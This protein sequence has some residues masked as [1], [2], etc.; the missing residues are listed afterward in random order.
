[1]N[2]TLVFAAT[3]LLSYLLGAVPFGYLVARARGIDIL[4]QGSGNI[5]ATNVGR[6]LGR[7]FGILVFLLDFAKGAIPVVAALMIGAH[8]PAITDILGPDGL[9]V[10]AGLTAFLGHM[11]P[12]YLR[13]KGGK[14]VATG[15][16]VV[17]VLLP[18][19]ALGALVT[20]IVVVL[21][22]GYVSLASLSAVVALC[23]LR[24]TIEEPWASANRILTVFCFVAAGLVFLRHHAN[25][26]RLWHGTESR[27]RVPAMSN[28]ARIVHVLALGMWFGSAVF[29]NLIAAPLLFQK[30]ETLIVSS[31]DERAVLPLTDTREKEMGTRLGGTAVSPLFPWFFAIEGVCGLLVAATAW[32]WSRAHPALRKERLRCLVAMIAVFTVVVSWPIAEKVTALRFARYSADAAIAESARAAFGMWH[33]VSLGLSLLTLALVTVL[34]AL[35]ANLPGRT[36]HPVAGNHHD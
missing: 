26:G 4:R 14:G 25:I 15:A 11:F 19:P 12:V 21:A 16:G 23:G 35:A 18:M 29:F 30:F 20:W 31:S 6:V 32:S 8:W 5:G 17:V 33:M 27:V 3:L 24:M 36:E 28:F 22:S 10:L 34:M 9:P 2:S 13:F 7:R 1:M